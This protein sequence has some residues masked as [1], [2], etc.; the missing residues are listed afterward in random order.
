MVSSLVYYNCLPIPEDVERIVW[1]YKE[2]FEYILNKDR[3]LKE[4]RWASSLLRYDIQNSWDYWMTITGNNMYS[5]MDNVIDEEIW[6][7]E[8]EIEEKGY[9]SGDVKYPYMEWLQ[10]MLK[11]LPK[12]YY[13]RYFHCQKGNTSRNKLGL[14]RVNF[15][16][17][18]VKK[19]REGCIEDKYGYLERVEK[20]M[21][22][23]IKD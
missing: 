6:S 5:C 12:E 2:L 19:R 20:V 7:R 22:R 16:I 1:Y 17:D 3:W 21:M 23:R 10:V 14:L 11:E 13:L 15:D 4:H 18:S 9:Y 8:Y